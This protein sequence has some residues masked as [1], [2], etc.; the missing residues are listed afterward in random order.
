MKP[1]TKWRMLLLGA[2]GLTLLL[3]ILQFIKKDWISA[4]ICLIT[5]VLLNLPFFGMWLQVR[6]KGMQTDI[7]ISRI[8][9]KDAKDALALGEVGLITYNDEYVVTW[10]SDYVRLLGVD[11]VN[12]KLTNWI[13]QLA[14]LFDEH[15]DSITVQYEDKWFEFEKKASAPVLFMRNITE[16]YTLR[17]KLSQDEIVVGMMCLDNYSEYQSYDDEE[18]LNEINTR[19]RA[20]LVTWAKVNGIFARRVRSD[21]YLML[22]DVKI[23]KKLR[24]QNFQI[25][26]QTKDVAD[27]LD[28]SITLSMA[29]AYGTSSFVTLDGMLNDLMELVQSR[30]GDQVV[31]RRDNEKPEYIGGNSEK[32]TQRSKVRVRIMSGSIQDLIRESPKVFIL[33]H[34]NTDYDCMGAALAASNWAKQMGKE[35]YIVL[36]DVPRDRQLQETM[37]RYKQPI[38]SRHSFITEE[39]ALRMADPEKDL[40]LMVDHGV[41]AISSGPNLLKNADRIVVVDHHR[42]GDQFVPNPLLAYVESTAS[43][44]A[45]LMTEML[46]SSS[47]SIPIYEAE[48][49]IMYLGMLVDTDH[50]RSHTGERTFQAA[51]TLRY[52]GANGEVAEKALQEDYSTFARKNE[53]IRQAYRYN[54]E[55]MIAPLNQPVDRTTMSQISDML[56]Q[57]KGIRAAFTVAINNHNG[58]IAVSSRSDGTFN[59]QK[60]M[61]AMDGGGHFAAAAV[62]R[63][64]STVGEVV[65]EL[66]NQLKNDPA[67]SGEGPNRGDS[68]ESHSA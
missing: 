23:L 44:T 5:L 52:W 60:I 12:R 57:I 21:R 7:D 34:Q 40:M 25:L 42:R 4:L 16:L 67:R 36:K 6:R 18:V 47:H 65:E 68:Y 15:V 45:E 66:E 33:G 50:F 32:T 53:L 29:F 55:I 9:G 62:E 27:H 31:I 30:G 8:L 24:E 10:T 19:L 49:T 64:N 58:N 13:P 20:P 2:D 48:A 41:P 54:D 3:I 22:L 51:S 1:F 14:Q 17:Q 56:L 39:E 37:D 35:A 61:E 38:F 28:V 26:Q 43:S 59:V 11:I 46:Q 63:S